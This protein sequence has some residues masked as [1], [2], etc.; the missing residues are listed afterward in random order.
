VD[1]K[2]IVS[3]SDPAQPGQLRFNIVPSGVQMFL[4]HGIV[5]SDS[6]IALIAKQ[7]PKGNDVVHTVPEG[8]NGR[9][10]VV[11]HTHQ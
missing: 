6:S 1:P 5:Q 2:E 9:I 3:L 11:V 10:N 8:R 7:S 4:G